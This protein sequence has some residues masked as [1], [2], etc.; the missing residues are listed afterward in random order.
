MHPLEDTNGRITR[1]LTDLALAQE[2]KQGIRLYA[3]SATILA[4][5]NDYYRTME[6]SQ[7]Q[8]TYIT[9]WLLWF[10]KLW[11]VV[12]KLLSIKLTKLLLKVSF[13]RFSRKGALQRAN[14]NY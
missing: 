8:T 1:A 4:N 5:L 6:R 13:G 14:N 11:I 2:D 7:R 3:M 12:F 9:M 10:L